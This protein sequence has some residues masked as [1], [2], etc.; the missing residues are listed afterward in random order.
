MTPPQEP[1][2]DRALSAPRPAPLSDAERPSDLQIESI[3][4]KLHTGE[5]GPNDLSIAQ[6]LVCVEHLTEQA[7]TTHEVAELMRINERSVRRLRAAARADRRVSPDPLLGDDLLGEFERLTAASIARLTRLAR[8]PSTPAY[9]R[10][11]AEE[12]V[13]RNYQRFIETAR[14]MGYTESGTGRIQ[15]LREQDP[16]QMQWT[17]DRLK[18][19]EG[20]VRG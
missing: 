10:L 5:L 13:S 1:T 3:I 14:R 19:M 12:A 20:L 2:T 6:R 18:R 7:F 16:A 4:Q 15:R 11:W 9:C 17:R 8:D